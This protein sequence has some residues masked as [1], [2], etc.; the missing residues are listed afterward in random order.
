MAHGDGLENS[1]TWKKGKEG[2]EITELVADSEGR[3]RENT[4]S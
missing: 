3:V 2:V 1:K 4:E